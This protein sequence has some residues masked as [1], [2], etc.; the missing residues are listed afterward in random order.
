MAGYWNELY[1]GHNLNYAE[2]SLMVEVSP[3]GTTR[4]PKSETA[5]SLK[6]KGVIRLIAVEPFYWVVQLA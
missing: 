1:K 2:L 6:A 5:R 4:I 3:I